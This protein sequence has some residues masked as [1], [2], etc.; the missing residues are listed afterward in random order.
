MS[1]VNAGVE[2]GAL[3]LELAAP[4]RRTGSGL[5]S[6][7]SGLSIDAATLVRSVRAR[8]RLGEGY[9]E[10]RGELIFLAGG[11]ELGRLQLRAGP[12]PRLCVGDSV[13]EISGLAAAQAAAEKL[14]ALASRVPQLD[15]FGK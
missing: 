11:V 6:L 9:D 13:E 14:R 5:D 15:L 12:L 8:A 7:L 4:D 1:L 10:K 3:L 2:G